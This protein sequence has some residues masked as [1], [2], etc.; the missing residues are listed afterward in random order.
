MSRDLNALFCWALVSALRCCSEVTC[1]GLWVTLYYREATNHTYSDD[2]NIAIGKLCCA[3]QEG[4]QRRRELE[5]AKV[6]APTVN[7]T[8]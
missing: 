6:T 1:E 4:E 8:F 7:K 2:A 3:F 5:G